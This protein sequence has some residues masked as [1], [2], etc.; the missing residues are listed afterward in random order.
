MYGEANVL[1]HIL[2]LEQSLYEMTR[3]SAPPWNSTKRWFY[4]NSTFSIKPS[5]K[6]KYHKTHSG[7]P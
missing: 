3:G 5:N 4:C 7:K 6:I 1:G 2:F